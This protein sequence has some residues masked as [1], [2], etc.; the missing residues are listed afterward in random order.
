MMKLAGI[1]IALSGI[2]IVSVAV[3]SAGNYELQ[4]VTPAMRTVASQ[5]LEAALPTTGVTQ[6]S[7][8]AWTRLAY[9]CDTFGPRIAGSD[10][11]EQA[12]TYIKTTAEEEDGLRVTEEPTMVPK[13][14]RGEEWAYMLSPRYKKLHMIGLGMSTSSHG[15][16]ITAHAFV[17]S[18]YD[19]LKANCS[20]AQGKIV[21]F[22]TIFTTYATTVS[23]RWNAG[24]WAAECGG[25][26]ALVR[27][28]APFSMQNPHTGHSSNATIPAAAI[29]LEDASQLQRMQN[30]GQE[31]II[32]MYME[33]VMYPQVPSR[34]LLIDLVG[35]DFPHEIVLVSGHGDSWDVGEGALDDGGGFMAAWESVRILKSLGIQPR[36]TIR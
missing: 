3:V 30:R 26:A 32:S 9:I 23:V 18:G 29:S 1:L 19:D 35:S 15:E 31:I 20:Q 33:S 4:Y 10:A 7:S 34:N 6:A 12:L 28:V 14:V 16:N 22:N 5:I 24:L 17:V 2:I 25:V 27:T 8:V 21:V 11:L 13:W 36:R